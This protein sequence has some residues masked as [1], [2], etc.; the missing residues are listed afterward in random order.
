MTGTHVTVTA[1]DT[2][3]IVG[4]RVVLGILVSL[5]TDPADN[6]FL[7]SAVPSSDG[8]QAVIKSWQ[9]TTGTDPTPLAA[10]VFGK[11]VSY[12]AWGY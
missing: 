6:G 9:N 11:R 5:E 3:T 10:A 7:V 1:A 2:I 8:T 4:L 12:A